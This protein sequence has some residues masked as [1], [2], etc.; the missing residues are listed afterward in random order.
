MKEQFPSERK[1]PPCL[2]L[3]VTFTSSHQKVIQGGATQHLQL[4]QGKQESFSA[5]RRESAKGTT[6][7]A[8][9]EKLQ[10]PGE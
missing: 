9:G 1:C 4:S 2:L 3:Q 8:L 6:V 10:I 5:I 7:V